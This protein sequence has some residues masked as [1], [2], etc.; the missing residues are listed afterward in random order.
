MCYFKA[1]HAPTA[2]VYEYVHKKKKP[3]YL[4]V[5]DKNGGV[6]AIW[7][8]LPT[9]PPLA[10]RRL[11]EAGEG[12]LLW[13]SSLQW[14]VAPSKTSNLTVSS[15]TEC[16][17]YKSTKCRI[18]PYALLPQTA[19]GP[20][21]QNTSYYAPRTTGTYNSTLPRIIVCTEPAQPRYFATPLV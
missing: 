16:P 17:T 3:P 14:T 6:P 5:E 12:L 4:S 7:C 1:V 8:V 10:T 9:W 2:R 18:P 21:Q 19:S 11:E 13:R 20:H 15:Q